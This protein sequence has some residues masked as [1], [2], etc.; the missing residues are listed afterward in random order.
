MRGVGFVTSLIAH[1]GISATDVPHHLRSLVDAL[2][3]E[4]NRSDEE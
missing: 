2:V 3:Y 4:S 1:R